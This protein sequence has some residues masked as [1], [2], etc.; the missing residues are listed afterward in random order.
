[1]ANNTRADSEQERSTKKAMHGYL[2][3]SEISSIFESGLMTNRKQTKQNSTGIS[4]QGVKRNLK[5]G[6][7]QSKVP[8]LHSFNL[9][10]CQYQVCF[11]RYVQ[12]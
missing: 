1:M 9:P 5:C 8:S 10:L 2:R 6:Y 11:T 7:A 4:E 12:K 3:R